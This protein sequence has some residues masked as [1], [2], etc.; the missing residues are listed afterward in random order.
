MKDRERIKKLTEALEHLAAIDTSVLDPYT[1]THHTQLVNLV[2]HELS[3][4]RS[5]E[6]GAIRKASNKVI[7]ETRQALQQSEGVS[8]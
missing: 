2:N 5:R 3:R 8:Q 1:R 4:R 6:H 7:R